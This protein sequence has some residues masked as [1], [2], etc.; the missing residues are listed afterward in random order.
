MTLS[1]QI[2]LPRCRNRDN[3]SLLMLGGPLCGQLGVW[4]RLAASRSVKSRFRSRSG[5]Q[6]ARTPILQFLAPVN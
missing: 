6:R 4:L 2:H 5:P 1:A 3:G